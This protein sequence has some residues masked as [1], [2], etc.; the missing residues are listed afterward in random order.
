MKATYKKAVDAI[1][2]TQS[3]ITST[4]GDASSRASIFLQRKCTKLQNSI[5]T[6]HNGE[7][8]PEFDHWLTKPRYWLH[9]HNFTL[10]FKVLNKKIELETFKY[11]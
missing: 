6:N 9:I 8:G 7:F 10:R 2:S 5:T 1:H 4:R 11:I 3:Q